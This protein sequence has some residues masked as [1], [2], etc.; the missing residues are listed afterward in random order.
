MGWWTPSSAIPKPIITCSDRKGMP[1]MG[2]K[3]KAPAVGHNSGAVNH[4]QLQSFVDRIER[5]ETEKSAL[6]EDIREVYSEAKSHG[7]DT[8]IMREVIKLRKMDQ[9]D[10]LEREAL[11]EIY[12]N[13]LGMLADTPLGKAAIESVG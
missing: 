7:F 1:Q 4:A 3:R 2:F 12:M 6:V 10:R 8:K 5:L 13:A 11:I 9:A